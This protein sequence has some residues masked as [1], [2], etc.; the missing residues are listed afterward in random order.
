[1]SLTLQVLLALAF[2]FGLGLPLAGVETGPGAT[3][4]RG[5]E[6]IGTL[7]I[8]AIRMTVI[9]LVVSSLIVGVTSAPDPK[10]VGRI[11]ARAILLFV[12]VLAAASG[13]GVLVGSPLLGQL[14]LD[15]AAVAAMQASAASAGAQAAEGA[16][17]VPSFAEWVVALVPP[18]PIKAAADGAML[19]LILA[20]VA[21][22]IALLQVPE[23]RRRPVIQV[24][25][26]VMEA[27]LT[28]V[29]AILRFAPL[30]V[31]ALTVGLA[32]KVG[33]SA[34]A[35][36]AG[37]IGLVSAICVVFMGGVLYPA[38]VVW[39]RTPL[40]AFARAA[41]P[42][43]TIAF[44]SRSSLA[45]LPAMLEA[46]R[47][48]LQLPPTIGNFLIPL[49]STMFRAGAGIGQTVGVLFI[50]R[51]YGVDLDLA[52]LLTIALTSV[53]TSFSVPGIP[54]GSILVMVPVLMAAGIPVEGIGIL[55]GADTIPDMFRTTT[56]VTGHL[57]AAV[58]LARTERPAT[59]ATPAATG[60][61]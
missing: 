47:D 55:L 56:N 30:G 61:T 39:G 43:Q 16:K 21:F 37:Y 10:T 1:M 17:A 57:T 6:P 14:P 36:L 23:A 48:R 41:L 19:P 22:A 25:D 50:A 34:L 31:F 12:V 8:N 49:A 52:Q 54:G 29:R 44:S 13:V 4:L 38:A 28:L 59:T 32:A 60:S 11:G 7:F 20:S 53:V 27:S 26:G 40:R 9:P 3:V 45:A 5:L 33:V 24:L 42:A 46:V 15:P 51:L 58:I 18:N 35:A 2:G